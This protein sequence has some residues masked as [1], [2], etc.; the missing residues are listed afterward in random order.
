MQGVRR[1]QRLPAQ[2]DQEQVQDV[3]SRQGRVH[4]AGSRGALRH[5][6]TFFC[7]GQCLLPGLM[8]VLLNGKKQKFKSKLRHTEASCAHGPVQDLTT[9]PTCS[10]TLM[11][12]SALPTQ[13]HAATQAIHRFK[14]PLS[15]SLSA[16]A[17]SVPLSHYKR[18][19]G[20][21]SYTNHWPKAKGRGPV[22]GQRFVGSFSLTTQNLDLRI[23]GRGNRCE[24][25][26]L[27]PVM[28]RP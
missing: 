18:R 12:T 17:F 28:T 2:S 15:C 14:V 23:P 3:H 13:Q 16:A 25:Q 22:I 21:N 1:G 6:H 9:Q 5:T 20:T 11:H 10:V 19:T 26:K 24:H 27:L 7:T 8:C 4:A